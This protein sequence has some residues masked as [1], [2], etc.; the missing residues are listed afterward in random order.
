MKLISNE[1]LIQLHTYVVG[2]T[3]VG[4]QIVIGDFEMSLEEGVNYLINNIPDFIKTVLQI[5]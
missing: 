1:Q 2:S 3:Y 4:W 5:D